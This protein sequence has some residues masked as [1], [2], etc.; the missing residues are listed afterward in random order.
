MFKAISLISLQLLI[1]S[2]LVVVRP[3]KADESHENVVHA[4]AHFG[5]SYA[6]NHLFYTINRKGFQMDKGNAL[7]FSIF[8]TLAIGFTYKYMEAMSQPV[9]TNVGPDML[10]AMV[11]NSAGIVGST[12]VIELGGQ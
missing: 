10:R 8:T 11:W 2:L 9:G 7:V 5:A 12:F 4:T 3:A 6:L 1:L